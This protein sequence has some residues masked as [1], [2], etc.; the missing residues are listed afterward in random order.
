MV[1]GRTQERASLWQRL[2][3]PSEEF[4]VRAVHFQH[5]RRLSQGNRA[6]SATDQTGPSEPYGRPKSWRTLLAAA[7]QLSRSVLTLAMSRLSISGI[8][9][10]VMSRATAPSSVAS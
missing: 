1:E 3:V 2:A 9:A 10:S 7:F 5:A 6:M 8:G 4:E